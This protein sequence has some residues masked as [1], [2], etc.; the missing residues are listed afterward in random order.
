MLCQKWLVDPVAPVLPALRRRICAPDRQ[1]RCL[2]QV[3]SPHQVADT[4]GLYAD[5]WFR[6]LR[7]HPL[8][9]HFLASFARALA[10]GA[11]SVDFSLSLAYS[12]YTGRCRARVLKKGETTHE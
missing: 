7:V 6:L 2:I 3:I 5:D 8:L 9:F 4:G 10:S 11:Q 12:A 1:P